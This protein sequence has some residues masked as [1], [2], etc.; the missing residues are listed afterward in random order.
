MPSHIDFCDRHPFMNMIFTSQQ[1]LAWITIHIA[2]SPPPH[3]KRTMSLRSTILTH[4][5]PHIPSTSFTRQALTASLSR[6]PSTHPDHRPGDIS[7]TVLD[8][9][10]GSE[11]GAEKALVRRW[12]EE[13]V[14]VVQGRE[15]GRQG[16]EMGTGTG[17]ERR[18]GEGNGKAE[19]GVGGASGPGGATMMG[20][21]KGRERG[22][23]RVR[24]RIKAR[25]ERRLTYSGNV[26]EHLVEVSAMVLCIDRV[27]LLSAYDNPYARTGT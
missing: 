18:V 14:R 21:G 27:G 26:G 20:T 25:L 24:D 9:L 17:T 10:Y 16:E 12:A 8:T 3:P 1:Y 22:R 15:Q 5:L 7:D 23:G 13:G 6:L 4:A 11:R 19:L 2:T